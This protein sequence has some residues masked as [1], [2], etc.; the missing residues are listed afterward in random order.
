MSLFP[1]IFLCIDK[2]LLMLMTDLCGELAKPR[3]Y[4]AWRSISSISDLLLGLQ[5]LLVGPTGLRPADVFHGS[6]LGFEQIP[7]RLQIQAAI[8]KLAI[9]LLRVTIS[10]K[11]SRQ[12]PQPPPL[13]Q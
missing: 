4:V 8:H 10:P 3:H 7:L 12:D 9:L 11:Q 6:I 2:G 1:D 5:E 13:L